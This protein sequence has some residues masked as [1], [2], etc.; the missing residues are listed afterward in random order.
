MYAELRRYVQSLGWN[1]MLAGRV[2]QSG[3]T[4]LDLGFG[5]GGNAAALAHQLRETGCS[6]FG[7][8]K[9]IEMVASAQAL[10][11]HS[12]YP[13]LFLLLG[14][15]ERAGEALIEYSATNGREPPRIS[16]VVSNYTLHWLRDPTDPR[17]FLHKELFQSLNPLQDCGGEHLHFCAHR[18]AFQELFEAGYR[19]MRESLAWDQYLRPRDGDYS[20]NG[21]WRHPPLIT[22]EEIQSALRAGG[23]S[24]TVEQR[25]DA[26][27]FPSWEAL[28]AWVGAMIRPFMVR[29]PEDERQSFVQA[30]IN[31]YRSDNH[32]MLQGYESPVLLDRN[33]LVRA[34]KERE[35]AAG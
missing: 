31:R 25:N 12:N 35:L 19:V 11:P 21:E 14:S 16:L 15:A 4:I 5:D 20:E 13:N 33:L 7:I 3:E 27:V 6:V 1:A 34:R 28:E 10:Y 24:G 2:F 23:Y 29:I 18:D 26:R 9:S 30:W 22:S 32:S 17:R 8:D